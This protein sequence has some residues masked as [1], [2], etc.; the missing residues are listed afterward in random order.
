[1]LRYCF[2]LFYFVFVSRIWKITHCQNGFHCK[3]PCQSSAR[4]NAPQP[5]EWAIKHGIISA[6]K[7]SL[8]LYHYCTVFYNLHVHVKTTLINSIW[9]S[10]ITRCLDYTQTYALCVCARLPVL[11]IVYIYDCACM[12]NLRPLFSAQKQNKNWHP[13]VR[14]ISL[15]SYMCLRSISIS[16]STVF[17]KMLAE[18][19]HDFKSTQRQTVC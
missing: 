18:K 5:D 8:K 13:S 15:K 17:P 7:I 9:P 12:K 14:N 3:S 6:Y 16:C 19:S 1:M 4:T 2:V 11:F 10:F